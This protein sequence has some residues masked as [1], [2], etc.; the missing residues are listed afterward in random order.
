[1]DFKDQDIYTDVAPFSET[2]V[3]LGFN[4]VQQDRNDALRNQAPN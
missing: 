1:M 2:A 4:K 3:I